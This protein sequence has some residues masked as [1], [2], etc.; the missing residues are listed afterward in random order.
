MTFPCSSRMGKTNQW[1]RVV[2]IVV[3][4][5]N[6]REVLWGWLG[7]DTGFSEIG[8]M[9]HFLIWAVAT[10]VQICKNS[11]SYTLKVSALCYMLYCNKRMKQI[12]IITNCFLKE[13]W[14]QWPAFS[15]MM[16]MGVYGGACLLSPVGFEGAHQGK[17]SWESCPGRGRCK[18]K[19]PEA[20]T[21]HM[22]NVA[23]N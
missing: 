10:Q 16:C 1:L 14:E 8:L 6:G 11:S 20:E 3:T 7:K 13:Q 17:V 22:W 4:S 21:N 9:F 18:C 12:K 23:Q 5:G 19:G 2:G 15:R